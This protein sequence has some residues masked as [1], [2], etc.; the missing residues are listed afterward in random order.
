MG[1]MACVCVVA[2]KVN[3]HSEISGRVCK[4]DILLRLCRL[5]LRIALN[6][7]RLCGWK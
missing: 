5:K 3:D 4:M 1:L 7:M 2:G 6:Q